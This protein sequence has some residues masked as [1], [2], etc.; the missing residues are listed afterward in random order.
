VA[1]DD[2]A[3]GVAPR[4]LADAIARVDT[5]R[6]LGLGGAEIGVPVGELGARGLGERV[7]VLVR[8]FQAAQIGAAALA[9]ARH[10]EGHL[11][12]ALLRTVLLVLRIGR[13]RHTRRN[14]ERCRNDCR[15]LH[16]TSAWV[17]GAEVLPQSGQQTRAQ[18]Y[19]RTSSPRQPVWSGK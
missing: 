15:K 5:G 6:A 1:G 12:A 10:E 16:E 4:A 7:A 19:S 13:R 9:F 18:R 11:A 8:A 3:L 14:K 17:G 2:Y